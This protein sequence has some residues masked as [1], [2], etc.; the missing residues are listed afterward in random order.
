MAQW[1][2]IIVSGS[3]AALNEIT[4]SSGLKFTL[5][6]NAT[7]GG[8]KGNEA[9]TPLVVDSTGNVHTGSAYALASGGDTVGG[10]NLS[11]NVVIVGDNNSLIKT[12]S[13][14]NDVD[15]NNTDVKNITDLTASNVSLQTLDVRTSNNSSSQ[16]I[17]VVGSDSDKIQV[18]LGNNNLS[19]SIKILPG[20][21]MSNVP[22]NNNSLTDVL[23][24]G[25]NGEIKQRPSSELGGVTSVVG[26]TNLNNRGNTNTAT[27]T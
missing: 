25:A 8:L 19:H 24:I 2:K 6:Q 27:V 10:T 5:A 18:S 17:S 21:T 22:D 16:F 9:V 23:V 15:F 20:V 4:A 7:S 12:A 14:A 13:S 1:K 3:N 11:C 26:G